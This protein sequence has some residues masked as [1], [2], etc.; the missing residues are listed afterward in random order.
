MNHSQWRLYPDTAHEHCFMVSAYVTDVLEQVRHLRPT[1]TSFGICFQVVVTSA[2]CV[3]RGGTTSLVV[4]VGDEQLLL[5]LFLASTQFM[6]ICDVSII[7]SIKTALRQQR[8]IR[9]S[10]TLSFLSR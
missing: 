8:A 1:E 2:L 3:L 5:S 6:K 7:R 9:R 4:V 10:H